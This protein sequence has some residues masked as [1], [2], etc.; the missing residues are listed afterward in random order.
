M[1]NRQ[2]LISILRSLGLIKTIKKI[3][4]K[5]NKPKWHNLRSLKPVSRRFSRDLGT[6]IDRIYIEDF[7]SKNTHLITGNVC[8]IADNTYSKQFG[9]NISA[10]HILNYT[11]IPTATIVGDLTDIKTLPES[12]IDCFILTQTLNFIYDFKAAIRG[13]QYMLKDG[14]TGLVTVAGISQISRE[15]M[16]NWGDYWRF[17]GLSIYDAFSEVFQKDNI[18][19]EVYGNVLSSTA[20]LQGICA[21]ELTHEE[22]FYKD[23][24][25]HMT[26][27]V[28]VTK[29]QTS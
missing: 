25:Y 8:E 7:L 11:N 9:S 3:N 28:K 20:F 27:T 21:E 18:E 6:P 2:L 1:I 29:A 24:D 15:D 12:K 13:M 26:I 17:T 5:L 4:R 16:D 22:L 14:G 19:I 10:F 23:D